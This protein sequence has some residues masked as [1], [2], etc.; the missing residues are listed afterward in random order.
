MPNAVEK[1]PLGVMP[2]IIWLEKRITELS[3]AFYEYT[4]IGIYD[5]TKR[6][7][8]YELYNLYHQRERYLEE[9]KGVSA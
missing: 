9:H 3:R 7:W 5:N 4:S 2:H 6:A 1:P 8:L